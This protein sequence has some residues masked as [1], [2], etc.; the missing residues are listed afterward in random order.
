MKSLREKID[1][2]TGFVL[3]GL[4]IVG[5]VFV[6]E[7]RTFN[8]SNQEALQKQMAANGMRMPPGGM[9]DPA[10]MQAMM[11]DNMTKELNLSAPQKE[12]MKT[13][14]QGMGPQ[15]MRAIFEDKSLSREQKMAKLQSQ[16]AERET[17]IKAILTPEQQGKYEKMQSEMR[18]RMAMRRGGMPGGMPPGMGMGG[19]P[20]GMGPMMMPFPPGGPPPGAPP[21]H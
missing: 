8:P 15:G 16:Q 14:M 9:P 19:P 17:R 1:R 10:R 13:A 2:K 5:V 7:W 3:L 20:P 12:Q 4:A 18:Q 6:I 21:S 11:L